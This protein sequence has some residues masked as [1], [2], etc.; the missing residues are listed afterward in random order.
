MGIPWNLHTEGKQKRL[1]WVS[2]A[3]HERYYANCSSPPKN[4]EWE[5]LEL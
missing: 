5:D 3:E 1:L 4:I 2:R